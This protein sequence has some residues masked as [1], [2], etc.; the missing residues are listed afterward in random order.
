M[1]I[2]EKAVYSVA[3]PEACASIL[4]RDIARREEAAG[5]LDIAADELW[6]LGVVDEVVTEPAGGA[7]CDHDPA[8]APLDDALHRHVTALLQQSPELLLQRR[9]TRF[10]ERW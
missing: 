10:R 7:Q 8:A 6:R 9:G 2:L 3:S 5:L 4:W 1:L